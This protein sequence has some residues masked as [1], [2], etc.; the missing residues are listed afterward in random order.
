MGQEPVLSD[1]VSSDALPLAERK[2]P[3]PNGAQHL[4]QLGPLFT[5]RFFLSPKSLSDHIE[6][7]DEQVLVGQGHSVR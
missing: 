7:T 2:A 4:H 3:D 6:I 5:I 1:H